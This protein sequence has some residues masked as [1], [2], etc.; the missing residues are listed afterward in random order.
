[1]IN[2]DNNV[3]KGKMLK[4]I[5]FKYNTRLQECTILARWSFDKHLPVNIVGSILHL[6]NSYFT[7]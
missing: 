2:I 3:I 1:M 4:V 5:Y 7:A 6:M